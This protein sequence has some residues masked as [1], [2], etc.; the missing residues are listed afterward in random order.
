[1]PDATPLSRLRRRFAVVISVVALGLTGPLAR[2]ADPQPYT[3]SIDGTGQAPLDAAI[4]D[5]STLVS[6]R[7]KAPV[8]PFALVARAREDADR[9]QAALESFGYYKGRAEV[10]VGD[11]A[12]DDP[13]LPDYLGDLPAEPPVPVTVS[14][15]AGPLFHLRQ[16]AIEGPV[17]Y[18]AREKLGLDE[19]APAVAADVLAARARL[20]GA[21]RAQG[22]ALAKVSEPVAILEPGDDAL[23]VT[24]VVDT[25]PLVELGDIGVQGL[26]EVNESFV[27]QRLLIHPG[28]RFDPGAVEK[29]RQD[30][31]SLGVFSSVRA[32]AAET[33]DPQ[34]R[35][36]V[37][38]V[39][40]ERKRHAVSLGAA[41]STD[42]GASL[43]ATWQDR[44]L[45]GNAE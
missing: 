24:Y 31:A 19:G 29:A 27:R 28:D 33:L 32:V 44:N 12:L 4:T 23:D 38:F 6:L 34:G 10:R 25:G 9:F 7:E 17:P 39:V 40:V 3:V 22:Y 14:V 13:D 11:R 42:L 37:E 21:L 30:L 2:A 8:G 26:A 1:M 5:S 43:T 20:L 15:Q 41:Y 45:F 36:P 16:V 18:Q 35:L